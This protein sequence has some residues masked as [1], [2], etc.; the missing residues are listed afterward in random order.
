MVIVSV[1]GAQHFLAM[2][3]GKQLLSG[4]QNFVL[5]LAGNDEL[6]AKLQS[7]ML[8]KLRKTLCVKELKIYRYCR[9]IMNSPE[10]HQM[11]KAITTF[12]QCVVPASTPV[13]HGLLNQSSR[14]PFQSIMNT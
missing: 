8:R 6:Y 13:P 12:C 9:Y 14:P 3:D 2:K 4:S 5:P 10:K 1:S 7:L 11:C